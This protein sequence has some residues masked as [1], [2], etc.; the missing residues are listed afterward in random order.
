MREPTKR[1]KLRPIEYVMLAGLMAL[2]AGLVV[3]MVTREF[4][5]AFI[6]AGLVFVVVLIGIAMLMLAVSPNAVP[7]GEK[8]EPGTGND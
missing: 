5:S 3:L 2:F 1:E 8:S 4:V 6:V 7:D